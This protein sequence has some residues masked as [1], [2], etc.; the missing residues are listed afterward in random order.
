MMS[1]ATA[2]L[3]VGP[4]YDVGIYRPGS[5]AVEEFRVAADSPL[6]ARLREF[7]EKHIIG[8]VAELPAISPEEN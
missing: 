5:L 6:L 4:P 1:T 8:L 3:S 2:N 7:W